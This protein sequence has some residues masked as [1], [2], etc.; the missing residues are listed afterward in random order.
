MDKLET[1]ILYINSLAKI[2]LHVNIIISFCYR[3]LHQS[4]QQ[5]EHSNKT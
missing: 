4:L 2:L 1:Q 3:I 5:Q